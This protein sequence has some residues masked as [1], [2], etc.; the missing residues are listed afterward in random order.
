M[1][2]AVAIAISFA[3]AYCLLPIGL[4]GAFG[5]RRPG[6]RSHRAIYRFPDV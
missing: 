1:A 6:P 4:A 5:I 3:I 2:I